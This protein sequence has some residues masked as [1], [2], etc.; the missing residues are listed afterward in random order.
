MK[1]IIIGSRCSIESQ[2]LEQE[3][4]KIGWQVKVIPI[5][6]VI[7]KNGLPNLGIFDAVLF[8]AINQHVV[9][10][11]IIAKYAKKRGKIIIDELLADSDYDFNKL[12]MHAKFS[13]NQ[14]PQPTTFQIF[15]LANL[16]RVLNLLS[17]PLIVKPVQSMRGQGILRFDSKKDCFNFFKQNRKYNYL[18]QDWLSSKYYYRIFVI[19]NKVLGAIK[20]LSLKCNS[21][22]RI[23]LEQRS[24]KVILSSKLKN[25]A[26]RA[27]RACNIEI[28]GIDIM[29]K[30]KKFYVLEVNRSPRFTRFAQVTKS[31]PAK[32]IIT[33]L[34]RKVIY[35]SK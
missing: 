35:S 15:S 34:H 32:E 20:R 12:Q 13:F 11:K 9:Q 17:V 16:K 30:N 6:D 7:F 25:L 31:N 27:S 14:V 19:N 3:S 8:R 2:L 26:L 24:K 1:L 18:I 21:R 22:P 29:S 5:K 23:P 33:Y 10:A 4:L 28:A